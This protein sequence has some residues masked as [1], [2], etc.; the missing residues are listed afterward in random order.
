[1]ASCNWHEK[2]FAVRRMCILSRMIGVEAGLAVPG[3]HRHRPRQFHLR[4]RIRP[5]TNLIPRLENL[6]DDGTNLVS[7]GGDAMTGH[8]FFAALSGV[9]LCAIAAQPQK[10]RRC[11]ADRPTSQSS[12]HTGRR[13]KRF[14]LGTVQQG[15]GVHYRMVGHG[16]AVVNGRQCSRGGLERGED[17]IAHTAPAAGAPG[18][19]QR[20][21]APAP[22]SGGRRCDSA[23]GQPAEAALRSSTLK[24]R[25]QRSQPA[26]LVPTPGDL[27]STRSG[28]QRRPV[29]LPWPS[30][31]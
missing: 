10:A 24:C 23:A 5:V 30:I 22:W 7:I 16:G 13:Q 2:A 14:S 21:S 17:S 11:R 4:C 8:D 27:R 25:Q 3:S 29:R 28:T 20:P 12:S 26:A 19:H 6:L 15:R 1:M 9:V 31:Q 18:P